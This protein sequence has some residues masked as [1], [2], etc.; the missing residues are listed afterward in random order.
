VSMERKFGLEF[1]ALSRY[2]KII[3]TVTYTDYLGLIGA[4]NET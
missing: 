1:G 4:G 2:I 3:F